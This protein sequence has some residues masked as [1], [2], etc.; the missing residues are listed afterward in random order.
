MTIAVA[1]SSN[2][3]EIALPHFFGIEGVS[4]L[5]EIA[6]IRLT[7][8]SY[9]PKPNDLRSDWV[10]SV[11]VPAFKAISRTGM[12]VSRF[13]T[14][15]TGSGVDA[16]AAIE[17]LRCRLVGMTDL[18]DDV[19]SEAVGNVRCNLRPGQEVEILHGV[20]DLLTPIAARAGCF[21][22][23]YENLPNIP[24]DQD[25]SLHD[26]QT[27]STFVATR[28]EALPGVA[29]RNLISLHYLALQQ[30]HKLLR[31]GGKVLSSIGARVPLAEILDLATIADYD[32]RIL[33]YC[34]KV[35]SEPEDVIPGY[36]RAEADGFGPFHFYP[37]A[38]L[39]EVF[40]DCTEEQAGR[41]AF[42]IEAALAPHKVNARAAHA[43]MREGVRLGHTV[44]V[45]E[46]SKG[47][48]GQG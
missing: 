37:V 14:I 30:A 27:S 41:R 44:A 48:E 7:D 32:G 16:L 12:D 26:G 36:A 42:E 43:L 38:V 8:R 45:L 33:L 47:R 20:G 18:H 23:I 2:Q 9:L 4:R 29:T 21:D 15:G 1:Q 6:S 10:A 25:A 35:Q 24:A 11:A 5:K 40:A 39:A 31:P 17:I 3:F 28:K 13:C 34:W 46:S 22:L 19:V